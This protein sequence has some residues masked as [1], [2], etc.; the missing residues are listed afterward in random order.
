MKPS[1]TPTPELTRKPTNVGSR[2]KD[3]KDPTLVSGS[4]TVILVEE[5]KVDSPTLPRRVS[6]AAKSKQR[7]ALEIT[8]I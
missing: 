2:R 8:Q 1:K 6:A 4:T 7:T 5:Q 3:L